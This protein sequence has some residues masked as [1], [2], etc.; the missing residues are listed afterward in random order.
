MTQNALPAD[1][2][3]GRSVMEAHEQAKLLMEELRELIRGIHPRV[4]T[5]RGLPA[6]LR[7]L[8]DRSPIPVT[9]ET[10]LPERLPP[11]EEGTA[12]FVAAEA[13]SNIAKHSGAALATVSVRSRG[14]RLRLQVR[15]DGRGGADEAD[16]SGLVGMRRRVAAHD[17]SLSLTSPPGG[18]TTLQVELPCGS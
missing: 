12:Y 16:G 4:L 17:G 8:A 11:H 18:P 6:A 10:D 7:E 1:S 5:D 13:L 3:A 15:D 14:G 2:D 9:V